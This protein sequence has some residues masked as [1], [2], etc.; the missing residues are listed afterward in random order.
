M[1][2]GSIIGP[3][4][5]GGLGGQVPPTETNCRVGAVTSAG[6]NFT[7]DHSCG[8]GAS[9]D[10]EDAPDPELAALADNGGAGETRMPAATSPLIDAVPIAACHPSSV[11][12]QPRRRTAPGG[13]RHRSSGARHVRSARRSCVQT[14]QGCEIGAVEQGTAPSAPPGPTSLDVPEVAAVPDG[15]ANEATDA[16]DP[17]DGAVRRAPAG[18]VAPSRLA[19]PSRP[20]QP[21]AEADGALGKTVPPLA[22]LHHAASGQ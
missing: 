6:F 16:E 4:N 14:A 7:S 18:W 1:S 2:F 15:I 19:G 5:T 12:V 20:H 10:V 8:L 17:A 11:R 3:T 21:G 13:V 9:T 22:R